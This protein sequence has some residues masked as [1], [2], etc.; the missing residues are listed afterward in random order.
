MTRKPH[1]SQNHRS[2]Q[3]L[4]SSLRKRAPIESLCNFHR[5]C[6]QL[7]FA[8]TSPSTF[9]FLLSSQCQRADPA[10][11][12]VTK[13]NQSLSKFFREQKFASGCPAATLPCQEKRQSVGATKARVV[14]VR[15]IYESLNRLSIPFSRFSNN[16]QTSNRLQPRKPHQKFF[17]PPQCFATVQPTNR[18]GALQR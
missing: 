8:R 7:Q 12:H 6:S 4:L 14:N 3:D 10:Q 11:S 18:R 13:R 9:L 15:R 2:D 5:N 1:R 17:K 16:H